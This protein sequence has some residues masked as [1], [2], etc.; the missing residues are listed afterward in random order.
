[1]NDVKMNDTNT[2]KGSNQ[3]NVNNM[4]VYGTLRHDKSRGHVLATLEYKEAILPHFRKVSPPNLGFP[5]IIRD[6][7]SEVKG[8]VYFG[9]SK[10]LIRQID[11]IEGEGSLY[12]RIIVEVISED[13]NKS[14]AYTYYPSERLINSYI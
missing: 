10:Q 11:M 12:H 13:K 4:F 1:M 9:V 8:E 3:E 6:N 14:K 7:S 2:E 5:F